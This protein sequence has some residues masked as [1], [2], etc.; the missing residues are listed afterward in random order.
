[1]SETRIAEHHLV[2]PIDSHWLVPSQPLPFNITIGRSPEAAALYLDGGKEG[3]VQNIECPLQGVWTG[4]AS[5]RPDH[6]DTMAQ[7]FPSRPL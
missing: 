7:V 4:A 1:M 5:G 2:T 3:L 6:A